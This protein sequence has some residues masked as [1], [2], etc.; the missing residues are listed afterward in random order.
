MPDLD[1]C[2]RTDSHQ[3]RRR[4]VETH[5]YGKALGDP[6][7]VHGLLDDRQSARQIDAIRVGHAR[8]D[9]DHFAVHRLAP[10]DHGIDGRTVT[11]L[12]LRKLS[13]PEVRDGEPLVRV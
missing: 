2:T 11:R 13:F 3:P 8:A 12:D 1:Y 7:P 5:T 6:H 10:V 4:L 9:T